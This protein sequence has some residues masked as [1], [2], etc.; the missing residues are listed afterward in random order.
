MKLKTIMKNAT[1]LCLVLFVVFSCKKKEEAKPAP[2]ASSDSFVMNGTDVSMPLNVLANDTYSGTAKISVKDTSKL[3]NVIVNSDQTITFTPKA[4]VYTNIVI[5]YTISDDNGSS[6]GIATIKRGTDAQIKT[7]EIL[8][9]FSNRHGVTGTVVDLFL[10]GV[11]GDTSYI[12]KNKGAY[13]ELYEYS[14]LSINSASVMP[15]VSTNY[16]Y[17]IGIDGVV[18]AFDSA[19]NPIFFEVLDYFSATA[20]PQNQIGTVNVSGFS[21]RYNGKKLDYTNQ[22]K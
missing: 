5:Q 17:S 15:T 21:I 4:N 22:V 14:E 16:T 7:S 8:N 20:K 3:C 10:Y 13:F 2:T 12:Y 6:V 11:D 19:H 18:H 9:K 1:V